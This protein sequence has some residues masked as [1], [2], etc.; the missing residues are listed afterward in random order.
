MVKKK[1]EPN[2][3]N[4]YFNIWFSGF[5]QYILQLC[6]STCVYTSN[7]LK[8]WLLPTTGAVSVV[9]LLSLRPRGVLLLASNSRAIRSITL[10]IF[11][12]PFYFE[13]LFPSKITYALS[14]PFLN[15][16][17]YF[18]SLPV[19]YS[20]HMC[21]HSLHLFRCCQQHDSTFLYYEL[22]ATNRVQC[23]KV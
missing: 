12:F 22:K 11:L 8:H 2:Q 3:G 20:F 17:T 21:S 16:R 19:Y 23:L 13:F 4:Y 9:I 10:K 1:R 18:L 15:K 5:L 6:S 7:I 14:F